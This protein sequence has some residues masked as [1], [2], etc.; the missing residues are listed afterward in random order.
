M[1][2]AVALRPER[3]D[4]AIALGD[5]TVLV[6]GAPIYSL[7]KAKAGVFRGLAYG[8]YPLASQR[9]RGGRLSP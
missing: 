5:A 4:A 2:A 9:S 3:A 1:K 8:D 6:D 7:K